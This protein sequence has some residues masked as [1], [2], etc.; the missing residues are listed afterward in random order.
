MMKKE[1]SPILL[2][3]NRTLSKSMKIPSEDSALPSSYLAV[4][5]S[6][7]ALVPR[8]IIQEPLGTNDSRTTTAGDC[9][10]TAARISTSQESHLT[11]RRFWGRV[12][13][14]APAFCH[15]ARQPWVF[16]LVCLKE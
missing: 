15:G 2:G 14:F 16:A 4:T 5:P 9:Q 11:S 7:Q 3:I 6:T 12:S 10:Q 8:F 1:A 13:S